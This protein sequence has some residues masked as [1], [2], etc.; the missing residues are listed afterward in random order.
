ML[1]EVQ[2]Y[3]AALQERR[4]EILQVIKGLDAEALNW[5]PLPDQAN[6]L[7][8]LAVHSLGAERRWIHQVVGQRQIERDREAEF[9]AQ[10]EDAA[11]LLKTYAAVTKTSAEILAKLVEANMTEVR[12]DPKPYTVRW[13]ILHTL[14]HYNEHLGQMRLTRQLW[15]GRH[16]RPQEI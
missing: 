3:V 14:E 10:G 1:V 15:E 8:A 12:S 11:E 4:S 9:R 16:A 13:S 7:Y 5:R 2:A 6:S